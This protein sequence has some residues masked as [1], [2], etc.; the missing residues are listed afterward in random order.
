MF[1]GKCGAQVNDYESI[2]PYCGNSM[3]GEVPEVSQV[4]SEKKKV[5]S[6]MIGIL[7]AV[8]AA[9]LIVVVVIVCV[10][11]SG[12]YKGAVKKYMKAFKKANMETILAMELPEDV[13]EEACEDWWDG[14][15][16]KE[17]ARILE[18]RDKAFWEALEEEGKVKFTYEIKD[19]ESFDDLDDLEDEVEEKFYFGE[20]DIDLDALRDYYDEA[21]D[22]YDFDGDK[23]KEAY[24]IEVDY[25]LEVDGDEAVDDT[26]IMI[27]YKY[28]GKWYIPYGLTTY[29]LVYELDED[30]YE[31]VIEEYEKEQEK[32]SEKL[33]N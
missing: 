3:F 4:G 6:K 5:S 8:V 13:W 32:V 16:P 28:E 23:I 19:A 22:G 10:L 9:V 29:S 15:T 24:V 14:R 30:D 27:A 7:A 18:K 20:D 12:G 33:Y 21:Y 31:D 1:C 25:T 11:L 17:F 2:C 26:V